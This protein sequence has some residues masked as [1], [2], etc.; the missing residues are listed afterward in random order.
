M[1]NKKLT[2]LDGISA[3]LLKRCASYM[4]L[5]EIINASI[6]TGIFPS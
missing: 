5:L 6:K 3:S 2:G 1:N 4:P